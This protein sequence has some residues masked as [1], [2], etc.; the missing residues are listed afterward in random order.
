M[1]DDDDDEPGK[2]RV[3]RLLAAAEGGLMA[4]CAFSLGA[5]VAYVLASPLLAPLM[6]ASC[7]T[8]VLTL[9][10]IMLLSE[11]THHAHGKNSREFN[12]TGLGAGLLVGAAAAGLSL[13]APALKPQPVF[14]KAAKLDVAQ[15]LGSVPAT[16]QTTT[17]IGYK[18]HYLS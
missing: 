10:A 11:Q 5:S 7:V 16:P 14:N 15:T 17:Q 12:L 1:T 8:F 3:G 13:T 9:P 2:D 4:S 18:H 6:L